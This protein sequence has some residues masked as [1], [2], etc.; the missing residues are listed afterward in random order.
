MKKTLKLTLITLLALGLFACGEK[1]ISEDD[2]RKAEAALFNEDQTINHEK[3]AETAEM[4][5][6]FVDQNPDAPTAAN[7]LFKALNL[8]ISSKD[9]DKSIEACNKLMQDYPDYEYTPTGMFMMANC[10]YDGELHDLDKA[11]ELY[12]KIISDYPENDLIPSVEKSI[13][14]LGLTPEEIMTLIQMSQLESEEGEW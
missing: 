14:Y 6:R 13:E 7:W 8:Y 5:S 12:E 10:I 2:L 3:A 11:R 4:Y 9:A 1:K